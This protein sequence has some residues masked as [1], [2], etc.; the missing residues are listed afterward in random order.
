MWEY[1]HILFSW[2]ALISNYSTTILQTITWS[3]ISGYLW[4][5]FSKLCTFANKIVYV[6]KSKFV[7][8]VSKTKFWNRV[9]FPFLQRFLFI[10]RCFSM[11]IF[12]MSSQFLD[13][14]RI[15]LL[16]AKLNKWNKFLFVL[17]Y[18]ILSFNS[19]D[20]WKTRFDFLLLFVCIWSLILSNVLTEE[21][22]SFFSLKS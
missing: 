19:K 16:F 20:I 1:K 8:K 12:S 21:S 15:E 2:A 10:W 18:S 7:C 4:A 3:T 22:C 13:L 11:T 5:N 17:K 14:C 6:F 9:F